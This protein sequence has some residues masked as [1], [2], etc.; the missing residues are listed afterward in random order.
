MIHFLRDLLI[1]ATVLGMSLMG[2]FLSQHKYLG[3]IIN[4]SGADNYKE[5]EE[6]ESLS[7]NLQTR[8]PKLG[9]NNLFADWQYLQFIQYYGDNDVRDITGYSLVTDYF[10]NIVN[11]DP[12]FLQ[13]Y[14]VLSTAN[15]LFAA[16]PGATVELTDQVLKAIYP[17]FSELAPS[18]WTYKGID[19]L[20]FLGD[21]EA[22]KH[23]YTMA[24]E[25]ALEQGGPNSTAIAERNLE[26]ASFLAKNPDS[27]KA[28]I[29]AWM[30]ILNSAHDEDTQ[31]RALQ[32]IKELG[33]IVKLTAE[34]RVNISIPEDMR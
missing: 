29:G 16:Q 22:A 10:R 14:F 31:K 17:K 7:V 19:Q 26:T 9:F 27:R 33:G 4:K 34:G 32:E 23:S 3:E 1:P 28:Q 15:S 20:L 21:G 25:W 6:K 2:I 18:V 12:R 13:A 11:N 8:V 30:V 5:R 24:A